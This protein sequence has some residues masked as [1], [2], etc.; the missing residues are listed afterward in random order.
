MRYDVQLT[1]GAARD[2]A[3]IR[4]FLTESESA[5]RAGQ[6]LSALQGR[7]ATLAEMPSRGNM[8][9]E[10]SHL[11]V[12]GLRELH[13]QSYRMIYLI[14]GRVVSVIA[15]ADGRRDMQSFLQRRLLR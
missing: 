3:E 2:L 14:E 10:L 6:I 8:P 5:A 7:L 1:L 12:V 4:R 11:G 9:R 15:V 13:H